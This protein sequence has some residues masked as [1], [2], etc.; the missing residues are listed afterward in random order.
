MATE[1]SFAKTF[2]TTLDSRP[3]KISADHV[4]DPKTYPS[5][6]AY[7]LPKLPKPM[8][9]RQRTIPGA[10]PSL[11]VLLKSARN[12]P[13]EISLSSQPL[14]TSILSLKESIS[15]QTS[16][17]SSKIK[18]LYNKKPVPDSKVLKDL[19]GEGE[20]GKIEFG[21]MVIGG[22]AALKKGEEE[23]EPQVIGEGREVWK[24]DE[25]WSDLR[26]FLIQRLKDEGEGERV[27]KVF[28]EALGK[29]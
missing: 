6:S 21:I 20:G 27:V 15:T 11:N 18:L 19:V 7:I 22:A 12:P 2:L 14:S 23:V 9:K 3:T 5:R 4:E 1:L 29:S 13:L 8:S 16:I 26:G 17:P 25:F 28:R 10:E 24:T